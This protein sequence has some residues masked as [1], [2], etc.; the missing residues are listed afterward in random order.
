ML[1]ETEKYL[2]KLGSR[3]KDA[4]VMAGRFET[5]LEA[6]KGGAAE[7]SED[8][9]NEDEKDQ[10]KVF[11]FSS[12]LDFTPYICYNSLCSAIRSLSHIF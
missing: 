9:E 7:E 11:L 10:A 3:L 5:D 2:Q 1:K 6:S 12:V 8:A 4:K